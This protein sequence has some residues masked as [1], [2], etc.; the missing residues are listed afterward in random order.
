MVDNTIL[1]NAVINNSEV[2][3]VNEDGEFVKYIEEVYSYKDDILVEE[4]SFIGS[5]GPF[6]LN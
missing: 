1:S 2:Y 5:K 3:S 6:R 4:T